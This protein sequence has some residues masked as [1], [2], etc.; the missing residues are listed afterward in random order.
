M[1]TALD[2]VEEELAAGHVQVRARR[3]GRPHRHRAPGHRA[4]RARRAPSSTPAGA[5]TT[6]SPPTCGCSPSGPCST[7]ARGVLALQQVLLR[8]GQRPRRPPM[9]TCPATPTCSGPSRCRSPTTCSPTGGRWRATSTGCSTPG[10]A[11]TCRRSAQA[12]WR[13]RRCRSTPTA[14]RPTSGFARRFENSHRRG[15]RPRLRGR[16]AVRPRPAGRAPQPH[17]RGGRAVVD[18]GVRLP[19]PRRRLRHRLVDA[20]AEEEPRRGRAG[21]GQGGPPHRSPHRACSRR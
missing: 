4:R 8:P 13:A 15:E 6:R 3:R 17:R 16:G 10:A 2:R 18:R 7:V 9:S 20:A 1:L 12:R 19:P 5:A 11:S 21:A 14:W